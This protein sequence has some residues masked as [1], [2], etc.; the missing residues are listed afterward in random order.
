MPCLTW[1]LRSPTW[2]AYEKKPIEHRYLWNEGSRNHQ[3]ILEMW[4]DIMTPEEARDNPQISL[5]AQQA[6]P[7][8][9]RVVVWNTEDVKLRDKVCGALVNAPRAAMLSTR[10][11]SRT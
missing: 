7:Y 10:R 4:V 3:G 5:A 6:S 8:E 1:P 9:L 2:Q 11:A